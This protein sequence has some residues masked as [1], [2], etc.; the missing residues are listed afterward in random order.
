MRRSSFLRRMAFVAVASAFVNVERLAGSSEPYG[1]PLT[2]ELLEPQQMVNQ[3]VGDVVNVLDFG[4]KVDNRGFD[5]APAIQRAID[6][7][8]G[9]G[10]GTVLFP[11]GTYYGDFD[12]L[13]RG[14]NL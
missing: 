3:L 13:R 4:A 7:A 12:A 5:N 9:I 6:H 10:G 14:Q 11:A 1:R 8:E 2:G